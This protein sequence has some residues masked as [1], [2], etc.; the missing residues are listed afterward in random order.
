MKV[1]RKLIGRRGGREGEGQ[2]TE[3]RE[4]GMK[5]LICRWEPSGGSLDTENLSGP[6]YI[7]FLWTHSDHP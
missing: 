7:L 5:T 6:A 4:G 3:G 1:R 2:G